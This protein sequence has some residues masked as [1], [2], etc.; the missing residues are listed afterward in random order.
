MNIWAKYIAYEHEIW[1][2]TYGTTVTVSWKPTLRLFFFLS[3]SSIMTGKLL[4]H[5]GDDCLRCVG[6]S[7][8]C[9]IKVL[10]SFRNFSI[11]SSDSITLCGD[12]DIDVD[13][14]YWVVELLLVE[15]VVGS[16]SS[17]IDGRRQRWSCIYFKGCLYR[18][19]LRR[20]SRDGDALAVELCWWVDFG[21]MP[22]LCK[23]L[24]RTAFDDDVNTRRW[25][26]DDDDED[27]HRSCWERW[28]ASRDEGK[29][30]DAI[31]IV[32]G[33]WVWNSSWQL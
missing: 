31:V 25:C 4:T 21:V 27:A 9:R 3:P 6:R 15:L 20:Y 12:D 28:D 32:D 14:R 16:R 18:G 5:L 7:S 2:I 24:H 11:S 17:S 33:S 26:F 8:S 13:D 29:V 10:I 1:S 22:S 19:T 30:D 23:S